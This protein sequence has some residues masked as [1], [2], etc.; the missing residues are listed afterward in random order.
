MTQKIT[1]IMPVIC[2]LL[3]LLLP[4][5]SS[6]LVMKALSGGLLVTVHRGRHDPIVATLNGPARIVISGILGI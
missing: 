6:K 2:R 5:P 4:L 1:G 3:A